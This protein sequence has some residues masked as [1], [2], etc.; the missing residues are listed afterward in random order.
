MAGVPD[1]TVSSVQVNAGRASRVDMTMTI[2]AAQP[3]APVPIPSAS[4]AALPP[5][6]PEEA[7]ALR[8]YE[9]S[10]S[11][12]AQISDTKAAGNDFWKRWIKG[13]SPSLPELMSQPQIAKPAP[14]PPQS[15]PKTAVLNASTADQ[16]A[17]GTP[18]P[19]SIGDPAPTAA[20]NTDKKI[21]PFSDS[22]WT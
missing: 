11:S 15:G 19:T 9:R 14:A 2:P 6:A 12:A 8:R 3:S 7:R 5:T 17:S 22:D 18:A 20:I 1:F 16:P 21:D 4:A 13:D 10:E